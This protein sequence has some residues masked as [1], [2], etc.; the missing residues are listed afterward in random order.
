M[1]ENVDVGDERRVVDDEFQGDDVKVEAREEERV[2][3]TTRVDTKTM[4]KKWQAGE[5]LEMEYMATCQEI[6]PGREDAGSI[7]R[8]SGKS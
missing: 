6:N 2:S 1:E 5:R 7:Y 3:A 4:I 8:T